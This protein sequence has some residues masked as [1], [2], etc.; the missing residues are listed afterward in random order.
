MTSRPDDVFWTPP[1]SHMYQN[2]KMLDPPLDALDSRGQRSATMGRHRPKDQ[3]PLD[4]ACYPP[5]SSSSRLQ[6]PPIP[7]RQWNPDDPSKN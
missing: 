3:Q 5:H 1:D 2:T 4:E 7:R 6:E